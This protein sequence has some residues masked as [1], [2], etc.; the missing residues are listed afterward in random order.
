[1][2]QLTRALRPL[3]SA[4]SMMNK[5]QSNLYPAKSSMRRNSE[6]MQVEPTKKMECGWD[7]VIKDNYYKQSFR[8]HHLNGSHQTSN[9][10]HLDLL[11]IQ[12]TIQIRNNQEKI[13]KA[14]QYRKLH[15]K[16]CNHNFYLN[17][18][19]ENYQFYESKSEYLKQQ[20]AVIQA[21]I[22]KKIQNDTNLQNIDQQIEEIVNSI[23]L[24][25]IEREMM[26]VDISLKLKV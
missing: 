12:Q 7:D 24:N 9:I 22:D 11:D 5:S 10:S 16:L 4:Q 3:R 6:S 15:I 20:I 19:F 2:A 26:K 18:L 23:D 17:E 21:Q 8:Y 1:M 13:K 25:C 14:K